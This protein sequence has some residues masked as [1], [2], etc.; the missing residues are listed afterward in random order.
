MCF[1]LQFTLYLVNC[2]FSCFTLL[3][4]VFRTKIPHIA[5]IRDTG[6]VP[7]VAGQE[8]LIERRRKPGPEALDGSRS[9]SLDRAPL[10]RA[11][12]ARSSESVPE[13]LDRS[14]PLSIDRELL[15]PARVNL[16][17]SRPARD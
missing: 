9:T 13:S 4:H 15:D 11:S 2:V 3:Y 10:D 5:M 12:H 6:E 7:K 17:R 14:R 8:E 1:C 16:D